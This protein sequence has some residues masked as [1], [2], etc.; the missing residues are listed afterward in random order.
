MNEGNNKQPSTDTKKLVVLS[1]YT[2][3]TGS[4][5]RYDSVQLAPRKIR[6]TQ[7]GM[8]LSVLIVSLLLPH[9]KCFKC[10]ITEGTDNLTWSRKCK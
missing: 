4:A 8:Q 2:C 5:R 7:L 6:V 1:V 10:V 9:T 3:W